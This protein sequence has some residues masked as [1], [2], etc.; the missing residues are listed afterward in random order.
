[1]EG[2]RIRD[3]IIGV[4]LVAI[5]IGVLLAGFYIQNWVV[6]GVAIL[7]VIFLMAG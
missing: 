7:G 3:E 1:M 4:S 5:I 6:I 2:T